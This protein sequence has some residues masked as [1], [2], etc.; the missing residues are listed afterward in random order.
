MSDL[1]FARITFV[2]KLMP[3]ASGSKSSICQNIFLHLLMVTLVHLRLQFFRLWVIDY[4]VLI[5]ELRARKGPAPKL[6]GDEKCT[7]CDHKATGFH[8]NVLSCEGCKNFFRRA[9][10]QGLGMVKTRQAHYN[11]SLIMSHILW[12]RSFKQKESIKNSGLEFPFLSFKI[13][14]IKDKK[15]V[16]LN[17]KK[18]I[19][20]SIESLVVQTSIFDQD[21]N[22]VDFKNAIQWAWRNE[23]D[24]IY[25]I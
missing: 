10:V 24:I 2:L 13:P 8:Y 16:L 1:V 12:I 20:A 21:V 19:I 3:F 14:Y 9:I 17:Q 11:D 6:Q 5:S 18:F 7:I 23:F 15:K 22:G 4:D 25:I